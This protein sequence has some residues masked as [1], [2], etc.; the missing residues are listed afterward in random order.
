[1]GTR[2][3]MGGQDN[4]VDRYIKESV[5]SYKEC[6]VKNHA[7]RNS[8]QRRTL[9]IE[10]ERRLASAVLSREEKILREQLKQMNIEKA[11][12]H[13]IHNLRESS[14]R[15]KGVKKPPKPEVHVVP[16]EPYPVTFRVHTPSPTELEK[17]LEKAGREYASRRRRRQSKEFEDLHIDTGSGS[18]YHIHEDDE[19]NEPSPRPRVYSMSQA[20]KILARKHL[21]SS[22]HSSAQNSPRAS[23][24]L[25]RHVLSKRKGGNSSGSSRES[26]SDSSDRI[27]S[28]DDLRWVGEPE[29]INSVR[30]PRK[31]VEEQELETEMHKLAI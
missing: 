3:I 23:P 27:A 8:L 21:N 5:K 24:A 18:L 31:T 20:H 12:H 1:M 29:A 4:D 10:S 17:K 9:G 11:K 7:R 13:I 16:I 26:L 22:C 30:R 25:R 28:L 15:K 14:P 6:N 19:E 2:T